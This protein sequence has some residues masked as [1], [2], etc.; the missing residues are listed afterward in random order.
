MLT[1]FDK[2]M[3][4]WYS[5][6]VG[7]THLLPILTDNDVQSGFCTRLLQELL[8]RPETKQNHLQFLVLQMYINSFKPPFD[9]S[10][11]A[12]SEILKRR[13]TN[14]KLLVRL[15]ELGMRIKDTDIEI[16]VEVLPNRNAS[17]KT[18]ELILSEYGK[19][20]SL[21]SLCE[22]AKRSGNTRLVSYLAKLAPEVLIRWG[23][24]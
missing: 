8:S 24:V 7:L 19:L 22:V 3:M 13:F 2:I 17:V 5:L 6:S 23:K 16:A 14:E 12:L 20:T 10:C 11:V 4:S 18:L 1:W 9:A 21:K 15:F